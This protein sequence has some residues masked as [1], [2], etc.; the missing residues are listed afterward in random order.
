MYVYVCLYIHTMYIF[1]TFGNDIL[2]KALES[3][4]WTCYKGVFE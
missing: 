4:L 1:L 2:V 3:S